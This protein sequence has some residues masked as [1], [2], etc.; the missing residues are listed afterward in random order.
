DELSRDAGDRMSVESLQ[1]AE[2]LR[3]FLEQAVPDLA[4]GFDCTRARLLDREFPLEDWRRRE[5]DLPFEI[6]YRLGDTEVWALVCVLLE[7]QSDT[8]PLMPLRLL[9]FAVLY[10]DRQWHAW[11]KLR[12]PRPALCLNPVLPIVLYAA[13]RLCASNASLRE[14]LGEPSAFHAFVPDWRPL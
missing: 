1:H 5:A 10:W 9:L 12:P 11:E 7:H 4:A 3:E 2:N 14:M 6:P 8:D 13:R